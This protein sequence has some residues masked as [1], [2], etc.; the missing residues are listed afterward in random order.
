MEEG[1]R[2]EGEGKGGRGGGEREGGREGGEG[3]RVGKK[4]RE[5]RWRGRMGKE[6]PCLVGRCYLVDSYTV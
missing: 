2:E 5:R 3:K 1:R 6:A 4:I